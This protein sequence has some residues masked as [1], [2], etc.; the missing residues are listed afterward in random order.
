MIHPFLARFK[1]T[2][3]ELGVDDLADHLLVGDTNDKPVL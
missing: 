3:L 1:I 2:Y